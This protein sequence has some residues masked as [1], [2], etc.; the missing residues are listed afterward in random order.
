MVV[1]VV[2]LVGGEK[3]AKEIY[4]SINYLAR[5]VE[6]GMKIYNLFNCNES[7]EMSRVVS[8]CAHFLN[9]SGRRDDSFNE[10]TVQ[11]TRFVNN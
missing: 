8:V 4:D 10:R 7:F 3:R 2:L 9:Q 1:V 11:S 5:R 6:G